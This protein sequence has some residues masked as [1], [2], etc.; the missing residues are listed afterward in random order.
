MQITGM[1]IANAQLLCLSSYC[2]AKVKIINTFPIE[3]LKP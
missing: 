1:A 2:A 3:N